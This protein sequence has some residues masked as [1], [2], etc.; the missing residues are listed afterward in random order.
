VAA[1][2]VAEPWA[3]RE[4]NLVVRSDGKLPSFTTAF[5]QFLLN[6]PRVAATRDADTGA[7]AEAPAS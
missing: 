1:V 5:A 6:D 3:L 4:L 2:R 7:P